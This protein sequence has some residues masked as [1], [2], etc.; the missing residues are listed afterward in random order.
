MEASSFRSLDA[1]NGARSRAA[2]GGQRPLTASR[3]RKFL[4]PR[5][6]RRG[7]SAGSAGR[8][9]ARKCGAG[10]GPRN[11]AIRILSPRPPVPA[12]PRDPRTPSPGRLAGNLRE[13]MMAR[14]QLFTAG[15]ASDIGY[16]NIRAAQDEYM[17]DAREHCE[18]LWKTYEPYADPE[19]LTEI[20]SNFDARYWEMYLT[21]YLIQN[22]YEVCC[23]KPGP[24][25]GIV[26]EAR[27]I[28]FE[29]TAPT[30]GDGTDQVPDQKFTTLEEEAVLQPVPSEKIILRYLNSIS[31]K[32]AKQYNGWIQKKIIVPEDAFVIA[33][34]PRR[35]RREFV[36][37]DPPR[38]LQAAFALGPPYIVVDP[39]T[40]DAVTAGYKFRD[41]IGKSSG[42]PTSTGV[43]HRREYA[44]LSGLLCSRVGAAKRREPMG[45]DFQLV[46]NPWAKVPL[47]EKLRLKGTYFRIEHKDDS[48]TAIPEICL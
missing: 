4:H 20:R 25:V 18:F 42:A 15:P 6:R 39:E 32:Y 24:D 11:C 12:T 30:R 34:N 46:P 37:S 29:A 19:F 9:Q 17:R 36:D 5:G 7:G 2:F 38:I 33:I 35:L 40:C 27:R 21:T 44:G 45:A 47:P 3:L 48:V 26:F 10:R 43:F 16:S 22:G 41:E 13:A 1:V 31:T 8:R 23:P 14:T 28:W